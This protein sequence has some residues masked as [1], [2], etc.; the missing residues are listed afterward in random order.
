MAKYG[1]H[2][3]LKPNTRRCGVIRKPEMGLAYVKLY[4]Q[5]KKLSS[6]Y[7]DY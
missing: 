5:L 4:R 6:R 1:Q 2:P 7:A 3:D